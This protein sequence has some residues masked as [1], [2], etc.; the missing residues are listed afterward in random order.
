MLPESRLKSLRAGG[1]TYAVLF[2]LLLAA[3]SLVWIAL[4]AKLPS[5]D[6]LDYAEESLRLYSELKSNP[7]NWL[8][9]VFQ[10][11]PYKPPLMIWVGQ[12]FVPLGLLTKSMEFGLR[13]PVFLVQVLT[14]G[15]MFGTLKS[16]Y[17]NRLISLAGCAVIAAAPI[18]VAMSGQYY[19]DVFVLLSVT[20]FM[21]IMVR[22][23]SMDK[24]TILAS[25]LAAASIGAL[26]KLS[27]P[28]YC[29][30]P[31]AL[32]LARIRG[33]GFGFAKL[34]PLLA[35]AALVL[36]ASASAWFYLHIGPAWGHAVSSATSPRWGHRAD[37]ISKLQ[38]L[39]GISGVN[40]TT[41][42]TIA[43]FIFAPFALAW[44]TVKKG[45][46]SWDIYLM[47]SIFQ[48]IL[49]YLV[50]SFSTNEFPRFLLPL[51]PYFAVV[52]CWILSRAD[53]YAR[54]FALAALALL[55]LQLLL[56]DSWAFSL[57]GKPDGTAFLNGLQ[58]H[59]SDKEQLM[60]FME[61]ACGLQANGTMRIVE[62]FGYDYRAQ[63]AKYYSA[64]F[65]FRN[66]AKCDQIIL[67]NWEW[68]P[69][70][71]L[72]LLRSY[73]P[74]YVSLESG[75]APKNQVDIATLE[76][77]MKD[78]VEYERVEMG[79]YPAMAVFRFNQTPT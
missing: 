56:V 73:D 19:S 26:S 78:S 25:I 27:S 52:S 14:L 10:I 58:T 40:L 74:A 54:T 46:K 66:G 50:F 18:F 49:F 51:L 42:F 36:A 29:I 21:R 1:D 71:G 63:E 38:I 35:F 65:R 39:A 62:I 69:E 33:K 5:G 31:A 20:L 75:L 70:G 12:F 22:A 79:E 24:A 28:L 16:M 3:P 32:V 57:A 68:K 47:A 45:F 37:V 76:K 2:I 53:K 11:S 8:S 67:R 6:C 15:I 44:I 34:N 55:T 77:M 64:L 59:D 17:F 43:M 61:K 7:K 23:A 4:D 72:A 60:G 30:G 13:L 9:L 48:I 41:G